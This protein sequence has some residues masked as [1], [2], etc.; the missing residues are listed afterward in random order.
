MPPAASGILQKSHDKS[1]FMWMHRTSD[2]AKKV[3]NK[4][5]TYVVLQVLLMAEEYLLCEIVS[6]SDY[7]TDKTSL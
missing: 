1:F 6:E 4:D 5:S 3:F 2:L 7:L